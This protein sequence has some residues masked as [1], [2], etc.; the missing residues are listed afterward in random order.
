MKKTIVIPV[1]KILAPIAIA[2]GIC[3]SI[4]V[5]E[6]LKKTELNKIIKG[7]GRSSVSAVI[8]MPFIAVATNMWFSNDMNV[9][10]GGKNK[11]TE[12]ESDE[13]EVTFIHGKMKKN[14][15]RV[16]K[17]VELWN[18]I[19]PSACELLEWLKLHDIEESHE[20]FID[21]DDVEDFNKVMLKLAKNFNREYIPIPLPEDEGEN[22]EYTVMRDIINRM[23]DITSF[24]SY[25]HSFFTVEESAPELDWTVDETCT[26][27]IVSPVEESVSEEKSEEPEPVEESK[28]DVDEDIEIPDTPAIDDSEDVVEP[29]D[30]LIKMLVERDIDV[31]KIDTSKVSKIF[32]Q[33]RVGMISAVEAC[34]LVQKSLKDQFNLPK[35]PDDPKDESHKKNKKNN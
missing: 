19:L 12:V 3:A 11:H 26:N 20:L 4:I 7:V 28:V 1:G 27:E 32:D 22:D 35:E 29:E 5:D 18:S 14:K 31:D 16:R 13:G 25:C 9:T 34:E 6:T 21:L 8:A 23:D 15:K 33:F 30:D 24:L 10:I 17:A 2:E